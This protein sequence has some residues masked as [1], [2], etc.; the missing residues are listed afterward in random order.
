MRGP[1]RT[2]LTLCAVAGA[3]LASSS[4]GGDT[5]PVPGREGA[6]KSAAHVRAARRAYDGAPPTIPH[7]SFGMSCDACHNVRGLSLP[8]VGFAPA[9]PHEGTAKAGATTRC[10]Q[11]HVFVTAEG[12]FVAN[13]FVGL[14]QD[15]RAGIRATPGAPPTIP[16]RTLMRENCVACHDGP[17]AREEVR[18]SHPERW[19]CRQCHVPVTTR[20]VFES[21]LGEDLTGVE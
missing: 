3:V 9:S 20:E 1:H 11:C 13:E 7:E 2:R 8:G 4:C 5:V 17:G 15:L 16:H 6:E 19:R 10:R 12:L 21:T 14:E 18:T